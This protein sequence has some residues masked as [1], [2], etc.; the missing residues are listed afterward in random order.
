M[1]FSKDLYWRHVKTRAF[2]W[3]RVKIPFCTACLIHSTL[4]Q[5]IS[6]FHGHQKDSFRKQCQK[7]RRCW[8]PAFSLF[9]TMYS[10]VVKKMSLENIVRKG[11]NAGNQHFLLFQ[12]CPL[13]YWSKIT[14][15]EPH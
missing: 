1:V 3:E 13:P 6:D 14:P 8:Q 10:N 9:P 11:D 4:A 15:F 2:F 5:T 7:R 12:Q